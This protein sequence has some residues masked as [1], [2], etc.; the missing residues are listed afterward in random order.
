MFQ[1]FNS[2]TASTGSRRTGFSDVDVCRDIALSSLKST[3]LHTKLV[4]VHFVTQLALKM[5]NHQIAVL[6]RAANMKEANLWFVGQGEPPKHT[7]PTPTPHQFVSLPSLSFM[8][9]GPHI[10]ALMLSSGRRN[11]SPVTTLQPLLE[12]NKRRIYLLAPLQPVMKNE[13]C[14]VLS[15]EELPLS[16]LPKG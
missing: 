9:Q 11:K 10:R 15:Q 14:T 8:A 7:A 6:G 2:C 5:K 4:P 1:G 16:P 12:R 3:R 13:F